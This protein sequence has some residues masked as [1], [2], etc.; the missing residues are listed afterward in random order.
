[1]T[2]AAA[3]AGAA[4]LPVDER[5]VRRRVALR[6]LPP[7]FLVS[8]LCQLDRAN[9]A[10]AA[11]QM[12]EDLGLSR[13]IHG[14]GSGARRRA[15]PAARCAAA[16]PAA[17]PPAPA[18]PAAPQASSSLATWPKFRPAP[19]V[20]PWG[21]AAGCPSSW[22]PGGPWPSASLPYAASPR[23]SPCACCWAWRRPAREWTAG[24]CG[25]RGCRARPASLVL[26]PGGPAAPPAACQP[27]FGAEPTLIALAWHPLLP[28]AATL[29]SCSC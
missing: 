19:R 12:D 20:W 24:R 9:L 17:S 29:Q 1:M 6:L 14:L 11:L 21:P 7:L 4:P 27:G 28:A 13:T 3:A 15:P 23:S 26:V 25:Q 2:G 8:L 10:F 18:R 16:L 5:R 22:P